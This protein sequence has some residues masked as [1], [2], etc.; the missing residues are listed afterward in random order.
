MG[1]LIID[2]NCVYEIDEE[3]LRTRTV[4]EGCKV[5]E[6]IERMERG[7]GQQNRQKTVRDN[8]K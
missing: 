3:C 1:R 6:A 8:K 7:E 2:G 4:P 5:K